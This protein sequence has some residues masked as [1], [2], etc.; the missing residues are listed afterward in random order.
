[1]DHEVIS[2]F[3][4]LPSGIVCVECHGC[5]VLGIE[6]ISNEVKSAK[7]GLTDEL[8]GDCA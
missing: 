4:D 7:Q 3:G 2:D 8:G 1:M 6:N 5:G